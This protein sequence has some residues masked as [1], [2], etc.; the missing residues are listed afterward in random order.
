[1]SFEN[2]GAGAWLKLYA[3][4]QRIIAMD[5]RKRIMKP[6]PQMKMSAACGMQYTPGALW[7]A[8][9]RLHRSFPFDTFRGRMTAGER[10]WQ[11]EKW[12]CVTNFWWRLT[13]RSG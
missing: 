11:K 8:A 6:Y 13:L 2:V 12:I 10:G 3:P 5:E 4:R 1:M 9:G 7:D